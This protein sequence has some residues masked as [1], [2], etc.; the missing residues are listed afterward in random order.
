MITVSADNKDIPVNMV[1]F[2]DGAITFK[3]D[4]LPDQPRY[5]WIVVDPSTPVYRVREEISLLCSCIENFYG[6]VIANMKVYLSL[7]YL[8]HAR[9]DRVFEKGNP[10]PLYDF[11]VWLDNIRFSKIFVNDIHNAKILE[12]YRVDNLIEKSQL[13]CFKESLS[14]DFNTDYD[15]ILSPDKGSREKART[16]AEHLEVEIY[17]CEKER[18][19][20]TGKI[21]RSV[22]PVG[23]DFS[24]KKV[25]I[26]DDLCDGG[27]TFIKLAELLKESG[28]KQVDLYVTH[29]I[30]AKGLDNFKGL[31]DN[32][33]CYQTVGCYINKQNVS[34]FN[35]RY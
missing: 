31:I 12:E 29:L 6:E 30:A 24:G 33:Y 13:Q 8:P 27:Y 5:I 17:N 28:A 4:S 21:I 34:D 3:L 26:P 23:V 11:L 20:S 35:E 2:S 1:E 18:D 7:E 16:I 25:L 9:A 14:Y 19:V 22:L 10:S 32:I 15:I